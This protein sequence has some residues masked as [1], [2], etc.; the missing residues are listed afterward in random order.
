MPKL[1][2]ICLTSSSNASLDFAELK[3]PKLTQ[4]K[5]NDSRPVA[6]SLFRYLDNSPEIT[7]IC[8]NDCEFSSWFEVFAVLE[9]FCHTLQRLELQ[10]LRLDGTDRLSEYF[11]SLRYLKL[12]DCKIDKTLLMTFISLCPRL[13]EVH[14]DCFSD[15]DDDV[16]LLLCQKLKHLKILTL[17]S[18]YITDSSADYIV[19]HCHTLKQ[20]F[21]RSYKL[22][23]D[24]KE[25]LKSLKNVRLNVK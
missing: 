1:E 23:N 19:K 21:I 14:L 3:N 7:D 9:L 24:G 18:Y 4:F 10:S 2:E 16:V 8:F 22:T 13:E 20:L 5:L 25:K 17:D 15:V 11:D 12:G 6:S